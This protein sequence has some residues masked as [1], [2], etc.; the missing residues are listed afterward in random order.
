LR[1]VDPDNPSSIR[2]LAHHAGNLNNKPVARNDDTAQPEAEPTL[3]RFAL[4]PLALGWW[5][6][7]F[8]RPHHFQ[9]HSS[10]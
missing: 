9:A 7:G 4:K 6:P 10:Q 5:L 8:R 2:S 1:R 3:N